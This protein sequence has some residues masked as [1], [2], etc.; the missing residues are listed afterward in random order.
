M[1]D[2]LLEDGTPRLLQDGTRRIL[3]EPVV[4]DPPPTYEPPPGATPRLLEDGTVRLLEDGTVRILETVA[5]A[6][7]PGDDEEPPREFPFKLTVGPR[8]GGRGTAPLTDFTTI[9]V[10]ASRSDGWS[11]DFSLSGSAQAARVIDELASDLFIARLNEPWK[12]LRIGQV[13]QEWD[14]DGG[15]NL[16]VIAMDHRAILNRRY[17]WD[18]ITFTGEDQG[19]IAW[20][21]IAHTQSLDG[22]DLGLTAG[23]L[24]DTVQ[25][26]RSYL[27]GDNIGERLRELS[28]VIG[29]PWYEIDADLRFH[30][31]ARGTERRYSMPLQLGVTA[32]R[33]RSV[34][35][36]AEF[37]NAVQGVGDNE[38]TVRVGLETAGIATDPRGRWE[39]VAAWTSVIVQDTLAEHT[40]GELDDRVSPL[41]KW[42]ATIDSAR[43]LSD[44]PVEPFDVVTVIVPPSIVAPVGTPATSVTAQVDTL[45]FSILPNGEVT[46]PEVTLV[47]VAS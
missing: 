24:D 26:I 29:G 6:P 5:I 1:T 36:A 16:A 32:R 8:T 31:R 21:L 2:R 10:R 42:S 43:W 25:R 40:A 27:T 18:D 15:E 4:V 11:A 46:N 17:L 12:R 9:G 41:T 38:Q 30:V 34:S 22:G 19:V 7:P 20:D 14:E 39:A 13:E 37:A 28:E 33:L 45:S 47:E 23:T 3:E 44:F 35:G